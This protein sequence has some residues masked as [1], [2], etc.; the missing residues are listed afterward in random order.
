MPVRDGQE[1]RD[2]SAYKPR[3]CASSHRLRNR[4]RTFAPVNV[5]VVDDLEDYLLSTQSLLARSGLN[6]LIA[7][8]AI[9]ALELLERHEMALA[10]LNVQMPRINGFELAERM[11]RNA[12]TR[13]V[14]IIFMTGDGSDPSR[15]IKGY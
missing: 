7:W 8:S 12:R 9:Q 11:R 14:P 1:V 15:V 2:R 10:L 5:L 4:A 13:N 3:Q 6:V